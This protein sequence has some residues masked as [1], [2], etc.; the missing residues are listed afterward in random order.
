MSGAFFPTLFTPLAL[1]THTLRN[2]VVQA[3]LSSGWNDGGGVGARQ[4]AMYGTRARAG[5]AMI[6]TESLNAHSQQQPGTRV[7]AMEDRHFDS[8]CRWA[9]AVE[10]EGCRLLGQFVD[11]GRGRH[12]PGRNPAAIG[13]SA[14]P[15]DLSWTVPHALDGGGIRRLV[16]DFAATALRLRRAGFSGVE[17]SSGHGHLLHQFLSP[18]SNQRE[19][20]YGGDASGR[21]RLLREIVAAIRAACGAACIIGVKFPGEDGVAGGIGIEES[22]RLLRRVLADGGIDYV[23]PAQGAHHRS[24][25]MHVPDRSYP[26]LPYRAL[27]RALREV[28]GGVPVLGLGRITMP[29]EAEA[30]LAAGDCDAVM[31]GRAMLADGAWVAKARAGRSA[32]IGRCIGCNT[33]WERI[34]DGHG[35]ACV[36][37]PRLGAAEE[38]APLP[39][40]G[41][42]KRVVVVGAGIAGLN[43]AVTAAERGHAVTLFGRSAGGRYGLQATLPN[44]AALASLPAGLLARAGAAGVTLRLGGR[45]DA[46]AVLAAR[47]EVVLLATGSTPAALPAGMLDL[48]EA[49]RSLPAAPQ[50]GVALLY[51]R[52]H[53]VGT[54][55]AAELLAAR[56]RRLVL[57]T[58]RES[59]ARD[60]ALVVRQRVLRRLAAL[61]VRIVPLAEVTGFADG[62]VTWRHVY[63]GDEEALPGVTLLAH[64]GMRWPDQALLAALRDAG[65][66]VTLIGDAAAPRDLLVAVR[67]G[68]MAAMAL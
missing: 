40:A 25:E 54:Y 42:A 31:M 45:A 56:Y 51:D 20:E 60:V 21:T 39:R 32:A 37:N 8:L 13:A 11:P 62:T 24:L 5:V 26:P 65:I 55:D 3:A 52:D 17:L 7:R 23:A 2:R 63:N 36:V 67:E 53:M 57:V 48:D 15:D 50:D 61:R 59:I 58:P 47:P 68:H 19:D 34:I 4:I 14:L 49:L 33:C 35:L 41:V 18:Q 46:A 66:P 27:T 9:A 1:G 44:A 22:K 28:A 16:D 10:G 29:E 43:A 6:V 64:A 38:T 30:M 12:H